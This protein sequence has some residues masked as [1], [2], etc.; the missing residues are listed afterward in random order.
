MLAQGLPKMLELRKL[1]RKRSVQVGSHAQC[2][3]FASV[4]QAASQIFVSQKDFAKCLTQRLL[5]ESL[6]GA[7]CT[8]CFKQRAPQNAPQVIRKT[9]HKK[10]LTTASWTCSATRVTSAFTNCFTKHFTTG[11]AKCFP[12]YLGHCC[13]HNLKV[14]PS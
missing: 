8:K 14:S 13:S 9:T 4:R 3:H 11:F 6:K 10:R 7:A 1:V 2:K 5:Y 12:T